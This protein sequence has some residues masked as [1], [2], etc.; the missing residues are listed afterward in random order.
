MPAKK[1][2]AEVLDA[3][4]HCKLKARLKE[5]G[6]QGTRTDYEALALTR[7]D[8]VQQRATQAVLDTHGE[9]QVARSVAMTGDTLKLGTAYV[10][11][12]VFED[13]LFCLKVDGLKKV[14]GASQLGPFHYAPV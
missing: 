1:V 2:T 11:D 8:A 6:E 12:A 14:P 5:D 13:D 7:R 3:F 10:L 9:A 4:L